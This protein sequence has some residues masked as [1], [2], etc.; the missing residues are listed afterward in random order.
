VHQWLSLGHISQGR[1]SEPAHIFGLPGHPVAAKVFRPAAIVAEANVVET[2][3]GKERPMVTVEAAGL[4]AKQIEAPDLCVA[5][6]VVL[7][8]DKPIEPAATA[9]NSALK[10]GDCPYNSVKRHLR[11]GKGRS[12]LLAIAGHSGHRRDQLLPG[13]VHLCWIEQH[14]LNLLFDSVGP[15]VP[16]QRLL[17]G[18]ISNCWRVSL[19]WLPVVAEAHGPPV[20]PGEVRVVAG[21]AGNLPTTGEPRVEEECLAKFSLGRR[22]G[23]VLRVLHIGQGAK[24]LPLNA[25]IHLWSWPGF[26]TALVA[27]PEKLLPIF[28]RTLS[29]CLPSFGDSC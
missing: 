18:D 19:Q 27:L 15:A 1:C 10:A 21:S 6:Q 29:C 14:L 28:R 8:T 13:D 12:E 9:D 3:I 5:E 24:F 22:E 2:A 20:G 17:K 25:G 11:I 23:I 16:E 7:A 4:A 26:S